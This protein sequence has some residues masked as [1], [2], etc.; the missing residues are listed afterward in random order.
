MACRKPDPTAIAILRK[1]LARVVAVTD[2]ELATAIRAIYTD[3]HNV[4]EGAGAA[5]FAAATQEREQL[6]GRKVAA[7]LSGANID[8]NVYRN[9]LID[10]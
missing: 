8:A 7:V 3:T 4:A 1:G 2:D 5:G 10:H 6:R 9:I